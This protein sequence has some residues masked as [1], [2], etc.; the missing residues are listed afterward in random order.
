M[1]Q[2]KVADAGGPVRVRFAPSPTGILHIGGYRTAQGAAIRFA[3]E[4]RTVVHRLESQLLVIFR[5]QRLDL[6]D[7]GT[8]TCRKHQ[9]GRLVQR[10]AAEPR[11]IEREI[12]LTRPSDGAL[13][14]L[15]GQ[16]KRLV[17]SER[18]AHRVFDFLAVAGFEHIS[19]CAN[20]SFRGARSR[21]TREFGHNF[22]R[23]TPQLL[24]T[25]GNREQYISN[26]GPAQRFYHARNLV[27]RAVKGVILGG[28]GLVSISKYVRSGFRVRVT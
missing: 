11:K 18:P 27:R 12:G 17:I 9:L 3:A 7:R 25:T 4:Q 8:G 13:R 16:F 28:A 14:S 23:E 22:A 5:K 15:P 2:T 10:N 26:T 21:L 19:H 1:P 6:G 20:T 24:D